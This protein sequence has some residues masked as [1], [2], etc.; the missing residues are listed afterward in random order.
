M[1]SS[2]FGEKIIVV[3]Y[4][5]PE[6]TCCEVKQFY[7]KTSLNMKCFSEENDSS[8]SRGFTSCDVKYL[9]FLLVQIFSHI[10]NK[11][12]G[13]FQLEAPRAY[14]CKWILGL[15]HSPPRLEN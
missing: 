8:L 4:F 15:C 11:A 5:W 13:R 7:E 1:S 2:I 6:I 10:W 12:F 14:N 3:K 9:Y